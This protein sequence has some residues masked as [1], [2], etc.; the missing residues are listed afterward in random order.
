MESGPRFTGW[1]CDVAGGWF[2]QRYASAYPI[3]NIVKLGGTEAGPRFLT[4][5]GLYHIGDDLREPDCATL[6]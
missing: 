2:Y 5:D 6:P 4:G 1:S 3:P